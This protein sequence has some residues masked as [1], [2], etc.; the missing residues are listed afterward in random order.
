[1]AG[2]DLKVT[3]E[4]TENSTRD[5]RLFGDNANMVGVDTFNALVRCIDATD[6]SY[7]H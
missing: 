1:M 5:A 2:P 3:A 6:P 7:R 4:A